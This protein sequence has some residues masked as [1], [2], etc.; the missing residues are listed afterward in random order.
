MEK[1]EKDW[2]NYP[3]LHLDLNARNYED[4]DS[5]LEELNK[6]L[7][8]WERTYS[9]PIPIVRLKNGFTMSFVWLMNKRDSVS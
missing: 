4:A 5:L 8:I 6:N 2:I 9:S 3:V 7:E 1:Q